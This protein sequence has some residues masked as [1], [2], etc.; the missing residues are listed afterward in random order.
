MVE[1]AQ[2]AGAV[3]HGMLGPVPAE[4]PAAPAQVGSTACAMM[5]SMGRPVTPGANPLQVTVMP[6][7]GLVACGA[8][9]GAGAFIGAPL[10]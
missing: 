2:T 4:R 5:W 1:F 10:P 3:H 8:V 6:E 9:A 7:V